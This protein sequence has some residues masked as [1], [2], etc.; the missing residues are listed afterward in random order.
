[1]VDQIKIQLRQDFIK[2]LQNK[3]QKIE[4]PVNYDKLWTKLV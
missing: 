3:Q 2:L 4:R 1:M